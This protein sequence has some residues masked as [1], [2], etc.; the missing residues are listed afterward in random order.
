MEGTTDGV[1]FI[2]ISCLLLSFPVFPHRLATGIK[3][4]ISKQTCEFMFD[5]SANRVFH[6][7][8]V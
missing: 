2:V 8:T 7:Y 3:T 6:L 1:F 5:L 4:T